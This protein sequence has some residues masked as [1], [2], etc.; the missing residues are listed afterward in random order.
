MT[1]QLQGLQSEQQQASSSTSYS[2]SASTSSSTYNNRGNDVRND[3]SSRSQTQTQYKPP[4]PSSPRP[5]P[6]YSSRSDK[7]IINASAVEEELAKLKKKMGLKWSHLHASL[8]ANDA[9]VPLHVNASSLC[10]QSGSCRNQCALPSRRR[11]CRAC[12]DWCHLRRLTDSSAN[13]ADW[14]CCIPRRKY[15]SPW[16]NDATKDLIAWGSEN[17]L[18]QALWQM[19]FT[20]S[21]KIK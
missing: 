16:H 12:I 13:L 18:C 3:G 20:L 5:P 8:V 19:L 17:V 2:S 1:R 9:K 14:L 11:A 15:L 6:P 4:T 7:A 10:I 21:S